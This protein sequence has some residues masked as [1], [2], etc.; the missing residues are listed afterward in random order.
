MTFDEGCGCFWCI[1]VLLVLVI[2]GLDSITNSPEYI[3]EYEVIER[4]HE[5]QHTDVGTGF[6]GG[7]DGGPVV[8]V[9][10]HPEKWQI[11][12]NIKGTPRT[13]DVPASK[14]MA[15]D[16]GTRVG[17]IR[18]KSMLFRR[19]VYSIAKTAEAVTQ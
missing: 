17:I 1:V 16:K 2:G 14:W 15:D 3:G 4:F 19:D 10:D 11:A 7:N 9:T 18:S 5:S 8:V 13:F 12:V 6:S